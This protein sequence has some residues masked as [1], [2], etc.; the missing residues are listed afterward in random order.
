MPQQISSRTPLILAV[1]FLFLYVVSWCYNGEFIPL[2]AISSVAIVAAIMYNGYGLAKNGLVWTKAFLPNFMLAW[3]TWYG[4][5]LLWSTVPYSSWFYF[6]ELG[7]LPLTFIAWFTIKKEYQDQV[8]KYVWAGIMVTTWVLAAIGLYQYFFLFNTRPEGPL[9]DI[10]SFAAWMNLIFFPTVAMYMNRESRR[11][12]GFLSKKVDMVSMGY[13]ATITIILFTFFSTASR[14]GTLSWICTIPWALWLLGRRKNTRKNWIVIGVVFFVAFMFMDYVHHYDMFMELMP[15]YISHN[16]ATVSRWDMWVATW[17]MY[18]AHPFLGTGLGSYFLYYP[19]YRLPTELGSAGTY[20]HNDFLQFLAEGGPINLGFLLTFTAAIFYNLYRVYKAVK[21][22]MAGYDVDRVMAALG[23][24]LG[25]YA[26]TGHALG[27]FIFYNYPLSILA[28]LFMARAWQLLYPNADGLATKPVLHKIVR[29]QKTVRVWYLVFILVAIP[30]MYL[31]SDGFLYMTLNDST[32]LSP[33]IKWT[34]REQLQIAVFM[35]IAH[36]IATEPH[37]YVATVFDRLAK[38]PKVPVAQR[39]EF[40][41]SALKQYQESTVGIPQ[42]PYPYTSMGILYFEDGQ[43]LGLTDNQRFTL[44]V[45]FLSKALRIKPESVSVRYQL[46]MIKYMRYGETD[47]A[48]HLM[49]ESRHT[50]LFPP[51]KAQL[52]YDIA[53]LQ[54]MGHQYRR[55]RKTVLYVLRKYPWYTP[56]YGFVSKVAKY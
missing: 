40:M 47:K 12:V 18:L 8:W 51:Q 36:P 24:T 10:N 28:G 32:M 27:N 55:A 15:H 56:V 41:L 52:Y 54:Y 17:H 5:T 29:P 53:Q 35:S 37:T 31:L 49:K 39:K 16:I 7:S 13:L 33:V 23:L 6:W 34:P 25:V 1:N 38:N 11:D 19:M 9:D 26:I 46:A 48:V 42:S 4:L 20:A 44:G 30:L 21:H 45:K 22:K 14:G 50:A 2:L 3:I 43:L